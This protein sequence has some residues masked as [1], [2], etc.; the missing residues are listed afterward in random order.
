MI[1]KHQKRPRRPSCS[2]VLGKATKTVKR[3]PIRSFT[4]AKQSQTN[5]QSYLLIAGEM[6]KF[7]ACKSKNNFKKKLR[8]TTKDTTRKSSITKPVEAL[9]I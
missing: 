2:R 5:S 7:M 3:Q 6:P 4:L 9:K 1:S 8:F